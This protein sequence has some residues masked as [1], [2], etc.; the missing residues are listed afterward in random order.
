METDNN[1]NEV[2]GQEPETN[3]TEGTVETF[4]AD[5]VKDLRDQSAKYRVEAKNHAEKAAELEASI[6]KAQEDA[7]RVSTEF[8]E[9]VTGLETENADLKTQVTRLT[10]ANE[11]G[12]TAEEAGLFLTSND[13]ETMRKAAEVFKKHKRSGVV[14]GEGNHP[15][16]PDKDA[17]ARSILGVS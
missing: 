13:E 7:Q 11:F 15:Q 6:T 4:S 2:E 8:T 5:Y 17:L 14:S 3:A 12:L 10:I 16:T 9:K 1:T